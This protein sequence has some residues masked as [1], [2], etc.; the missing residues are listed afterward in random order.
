MPCPFCLFWA[1]WCLL[2]QSISQLILDVSFQKWGKKHTQVIFFTASSAASRVIKIDYVVFS[3]FFFSPLKCDWQRVAV[4]DGCADGADRGTR[5][6]CD[7]C[8]FSISLLHPSLP[9][10]MCHLVLVSCR[11]RDGPTVQKDLPL[12]FRLSANREPR[13]PR[14]LWKWEDAIYKTQQ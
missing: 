12:Q 5:N 1:S 6:A 2:P 10:A 11:R 4:I 8:C 14:R 7:M 9:L 3:L 13:P